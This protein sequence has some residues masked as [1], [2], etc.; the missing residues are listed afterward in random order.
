MKSVFQYE[1][2]FTFYSLRV[3]ASPVLTVTSFRLF[4]QN[5]TYA[6]TALSLTT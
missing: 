3:N 1:I 2:N 6:L 5:R 4:D